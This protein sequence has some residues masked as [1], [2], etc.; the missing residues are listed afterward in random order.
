MPRSAANGPVANRA[1]ATCSLAGGASVFTR[2]PPR[3]KRPGRL[4]QRPDGGGERP[5]A[6][7]EAL[8]HVLGRGR[9]GEQDGVARR[10]QYGGGPYDLGHRP[11]IGPVDDDDG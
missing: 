6:G 11:I 9:G 1:G 8:E 10:R 4:R 5:P 7:L 2:L 3:R